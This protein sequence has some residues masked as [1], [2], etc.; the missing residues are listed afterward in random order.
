MEKGE[1]EKVEWEVKKNTTKKVSTWLPAEAR[2]R[3]G[4]KRPRFLRQ[5]GTEGGKGQF[6]SRDSIANGQVPTFYRNTKK[7]KNGKTM[8]RLD[9]SILLNWSLTAPWLNTFCLR[10]YY[11]P[12]MNLLLLRND[13]KGDQS[14]TFYRN[15]AKYNVP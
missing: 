13:D 4:L 10:F 3:D 1:K 8:A 7:L 2:N 15:S 14:L 9:V 12:S 11:G 6:F 5:E